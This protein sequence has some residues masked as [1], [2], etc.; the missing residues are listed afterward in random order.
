MRGLTSNFE[1]LF[2]CKILS[3]TTTSYNLQGE[4][5]FIK[6]PLRGKLHGCLLLLFWGNAQWLLELTPASMIRYHSLKCWENIGLLLIKFELCTGKANSLSLSL[7]HSFS[8]SNA[9]DQTQGYIHVKNHVLHHW[10]HIS[11]FEQ[12]I[13]V[14]YLAMVLVSK[15]IFKDAGG[16]GRT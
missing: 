11:G 9:R 3:T 7:L 4:F 14:V 15:V 13:S 10:S 2:T 16:G 1:R 8:L 6:E 5:F 12:F